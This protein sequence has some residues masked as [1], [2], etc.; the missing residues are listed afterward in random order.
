VSVLSAL[1]V[2]CAADTPG[3]WVAEEKDADV[4]VE[5]I[6]SWVPGAMRPLDE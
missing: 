1:D 4:D 2:R 3:G 5:R 6:P